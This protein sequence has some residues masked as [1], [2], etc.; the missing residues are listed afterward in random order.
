MIFKNMFFLSIL[1]TTNKFLFAKESN[2]G[3][4]D[5]I[6]RHQPGN[7]IKDSNDV[8]EKNVKKS[9]S[10]LVQ[11]IDNQ[12]INY[13]NEMVHIFGGEFVVGSN[14]PVIQADGESP[15]RKVVLDN[16]WIDVHEVSNSQFEK[17]VQETGYVTE[18]S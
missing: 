5:G 12:E 4:S 10:D 1:I 7:K 9:L 6:N 17:F 13:Y 3:C 15:A 16:F 18:V 14:K 11:T 8:S 2:C